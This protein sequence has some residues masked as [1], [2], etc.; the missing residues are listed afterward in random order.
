MYVCIVYDMYVYE[1]DGWMGG[2]WGVD[3]DHK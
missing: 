3:G 1:I 2:G